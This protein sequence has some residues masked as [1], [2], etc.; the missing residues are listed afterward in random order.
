MPG[1]LDVR[2]R[3]FRLAA[4]AG[5][6]FALGA[7]A[8]C[9]GTSAP[10]PQWQAV[11]SVK[12]DETGQFTAVVATG[13]MTG[14]AFDGLGLAAKATAWQETGGTWAAVPFPSVAGE[15][16]IAAGA[17][18][19]RD[20]WAFTEN[21]SG[22]ARVLRWNGTAWSAVRSFPEAIG[23]ATVL[24]GNDV[25]V[26][27]QVAQPGEPALGVWHYDGTA[28]TRVSSTFQGGSALSARD[29]WAFSGGFVDHWNGARWSAT[30]VRSLLPP[31]NPGG[32][33]SP[34]VTGILALSDSDVYALG[35][36]NAQDEGGPLVILHYNGSSWSKLVSGQYGNGPAAQLSQDGAGGLWLPMEGSVGGTTYLLHYANGALDTA[37]LPVSAPK[38]TI[39]AVTRIP[40]T[41]E[42]L[43]GG[44]TH[45]AGNR[46][47]SVVAV[48]LRYS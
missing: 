32:L 46:G 35:N 23:G 2:G 45:A 29:V 18:S 27:G 25:W 11:K 10:V 15:E 6:L 48:L 14:W 38:I 5:L 8:G 30:S 12:T 26:Y 3:R 36:G 37:S 22:S 1:V 4:A 42:L 7:V 40:G 9:T 31:D 20:V 24:S 39:G 28:W 13:K 17:D 33:N 44:F 34:A 16:V 43:A 21:V 47:T 19:P 41:T